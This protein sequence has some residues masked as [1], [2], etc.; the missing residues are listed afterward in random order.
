MGHGAEGK[1][2]RRKE[3]N[4]RSRVERNRSRLEAGREETQNDWYVRKNSSP[5]RMVYHMMGR[6]A[7][8]VEEQER[9]R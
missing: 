3:V 8:Q 6:R 5:E 7:G 2:G 1:G 9:A 4:N